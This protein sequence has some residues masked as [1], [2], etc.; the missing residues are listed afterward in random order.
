MNGLKYYYS[1][2][3]EEFIWNE[4]HPGKKYFLCSMSHMYAEGVT[5]VAGSLKVIRL[6]QLTPNAFHVK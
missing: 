1:Y 5:H 4:N 3:D 2:F 6:A